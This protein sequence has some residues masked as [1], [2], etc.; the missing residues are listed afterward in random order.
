MPAKQR[1]DLGIQE[2]G[3]EPGTTASQY[4][5]ALETARHVRR[6]ARHPA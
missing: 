2:S 3:I 4:R 5:Q 6:K 1:F